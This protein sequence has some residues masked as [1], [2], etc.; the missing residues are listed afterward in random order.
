MRKINKVESCFLKIIKCV[1][2]SKTKGKENVNM[3][4]ENKHITT[5]T[6]GIK[7]IMKTLNEI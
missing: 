2:S 7:C 4:S 5:D 6:T 1:K 3:C